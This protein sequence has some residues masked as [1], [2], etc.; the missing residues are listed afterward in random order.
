METHG[1]ERRWRYFTFASYREII[2]N[3]KLD[4]QDGP[5]SSVDFSN[6]GNFAPFVAEDFYSNVVEFNWFTDY[7]FSKSGKVEDVS[8]EAA[9]KRAKKVATPT[10]GFSGPTVHGKKRKRGE[11]GLDADVVGEAGH[12]PKKRGRPRKDPA[13]SQH[14]VTRAAEKSATQTSG[15]GR[16]RQGPR[17]SAEGTQLG[18]TSATNDP[19]APSPGVSRKR[20]CPPNDNHSGEFV[21]E[22]SK[23]VRPRR[24]R[25]RKRSP[26]PPPTDEATMHAPPGSDI[27]P[28][29]VHV[30]RRHISKL[31]PPN[32]NTREAEAQ[33]N[34]KERDIT[35]HHPSYRELST[36]PE[37]A[38]PAP[39]NCHSLGDPGTAMRTTDDG[40]LNFD[41]SNAEPGQTTETLGEPDTESARVVQMETSSEPSI[42]VGHSLSD[43]TPFPQDSRKPDEAEKVDVVLG[44]KSQV[45]KPG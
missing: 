27:Y 25:P 24:S 35:P 42:Y 9:R 38:S 2:A 30:S 5:Y 33:S 36:Q 32:A 40:R 34:P 26:L 21:S 10:T 17:E 8:E 12:I 4:D 28:A 1:R 45:V 11:A 20:P 43:N 22:V 31:L 29:D 18:S 44:M 3:E 6:V 19:H 15:R 41:N 7:A 39:P 37:L 23:S 13:E 16:S 14:N